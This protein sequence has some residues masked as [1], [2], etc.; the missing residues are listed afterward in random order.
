MSHGALHTLI[1]DTASEEQVLNSQAAQ[2][3]V[4]VGRAEH[5]C[6]GLGQY[7]L[8]LPRLQAVYHL[9][10]QR[11]EVRIIPFR[12][13]PRRLNVQHMRAQ[14]SCYTVLHVVGGL[15]LHLLLRV[16]RAHTIDNYGPWRQASAA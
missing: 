1:C 15:L 8:I 12:L 6:A 16:F 9:D 3:I 14:S 5:V 11:S 13:L 7:D 10:L 4:D 2:H